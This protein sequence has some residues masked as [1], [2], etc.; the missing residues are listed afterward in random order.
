MTLELLKDYKSKKEEIKELSHKLEHS[1]DTMIG[2]DVILDYKSGYPMPQAVVGVDWKKVSRLENRWRNRIAQLEGECLQVEEFVENI[3]DSFTRRIFRRCFIEKET[4]EQVS[5]ELHISQ[6]GISK[7][8]N[9][10]LKWN[11]IHKNTCY[12]QK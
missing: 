8:I 2:N 9:N 6:S 7:K 5:R 11:K 4:Q 12:N 3:Q 1:G 10:Y